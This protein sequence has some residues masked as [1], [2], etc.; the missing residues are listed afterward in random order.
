MSSAIMLVNPCYFRMADS[1]LIRTKINS[2]VNIRWLS[3]SI[4]KHISR[5]IDIQQND[6]GH[7]NYC[8]IE[9]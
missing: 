6:F 1:N 2:G 3:D 5:V 7:N 4:D 8:G 9:V